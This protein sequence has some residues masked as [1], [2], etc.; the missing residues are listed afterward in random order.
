[1]QLV[2][3]TINKILSGYINFDTMYMGAVLSREYDSNKDNIANI[4]NIDYVSYPIEK[5]IVRDNGTGTIRLTANNA[6]FPN[7]TRDYLGNEED[8]TVYTYTVISSVSSILAKTNYPFTD[9]PTIY[10]PSYYNFYES[11]IL[12]LND[13][14][15]SLNL[16][17]TFR[18]NL[19]RGTFGNLKT[20]TIK[21]ALM[22]NSYTYDNNHVYYSDISSNVIGIPQTI[23]NLQIYDKGLYSTSLLEF[24]AIASGSTINSISIYIDSG[25]PSTSYLIGN[26]S[27][28]GISNVPYSTNGSKIY[29]KF[30]FNGLIIGL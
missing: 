25:S 3:S 5:S 4:S 24:P 18:E 30:A 9:A 15:N 20:L 27:S 23:S 17:R 1:M 19:L 14:N 21:V 7:I 28:P 13:T 12:S 29:F 16:Y 26:Y 10:G 11:S 6:F 22:T 2:T 8:F